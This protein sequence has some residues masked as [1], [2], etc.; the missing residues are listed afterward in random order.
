MKKN[1]EESLISALSFCSLTDIPE[2]D[3]GKDIWTK[4]IG[5]VTK[6]DASESY[7]YLEKDAESL[8]YKIVKDFGSIS[9]IYSVKKIYPFEFLKKF[10]VPEFKGDKKEDRLKYLENY[11]PNVDY[12]KMTLKALDKEILKIAIKRQLE[13]EKK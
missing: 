5:L 3:N 4:A 9:A 11:A 13:D 1:K 12:S 2:E 6:R 7:I 10:Y 8:G